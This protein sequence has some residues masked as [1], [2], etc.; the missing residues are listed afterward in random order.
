[1][2]TY[3]TQQ[4]NAY[5]VIT[6]GQ[7][8]ATGT[9]VPEVHGH[10]KP[11]DPNL[12]PEKDNTLKKHVFTP[13]V[14]PVI[15]KG[16]SSTSRLQTSMP[17]AIPPVQLPIKYNPPISQQI[18]QTPRTTPQ[19]SQA[20]VVAGSS[21]SFTTAGGGPTPSK[22]VITPIAGS[23]PTHILQVHTHSTPQSSRTKSVT[24]GMDLDVPKFDLDDGSKGFTPIP[25]SGQ[26]IDFTHPSFKAP[27]QVIAKPAALRDLRGDPFL[28]PKDEKPLEEAMVEGNF[29]S[30]ILEDFIIPPTLSEETKGKTILAKNLPKQTDIDRLL[31]VLNR[32]ILTRSRFPDG[33]KDLEA[34]YTHSACFKDIYD[35][36]RYN[37]LPSNPRKAHQTQIN[38]NNHFLLGTLLFK[39][40]SNKLG[41]MNPVLCVPPSKMDLVLDHYHSSLLGGHQGMTKTLMTLQERF[42]C[43]RLGDIVRSYIVSC[44]VCQL[45]KNSK[46][47]DRPFLQRKYDINQGTMTCISMDIKHMPG[48]SKGHNYILVMLCEISNFMVTAPM[49]M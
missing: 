30:P 37:K 29:R 6:R 35:Y 1:M 13:S 2:K 44:H 34:A 9:S 25:L 5:F 27:Q 31:A 40:I 23:T 3:S 21:G 48:S 45:F 47:F 19:I 7:A 28:D 43:P 8:Q 49:V 22:R 14:N 32:K 18:P 15:S 20:R 33:L 17:R 12:K 16:I 4:I 39:L 26:D 46:R 11:L 42:F 38:A 41:V 10:S 24:R 36:L